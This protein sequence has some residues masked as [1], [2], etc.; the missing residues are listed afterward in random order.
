[1]GWRSKRRRAAEVPPARGARW[2]QRGRAGHAPLSSAR[3]INGAN[4]L[5]AGGR[6]RAA[7][8][9]A[10]VAAACDVPDPESE[11]D[12][13]SSPE[14]VPSDCPPPPPAMNP[15]AVEA[16]EEVNRIRKSVG[17][18]C[19]ELVP[20][21]A[22][23]AERHCQYFVS[24]AGACISRPHRESSDCRSFFG[25]TF[26]DRLRAAGY[27]RPSALRSDGLR[28]RRSNL[29]PDVARLCLAPVADPEPRRRA[30]RIR[31]RRPL[32][33]RRLRRRPRPVPCVARRRL[34]PRRPAQRPARLRRPRS[35][36]APT[37]P[38]RGWPS[39]YPITLY[40]A[41]LRVHDHRITV[42]GTDTPLDHEFLS[43]EDPRSEGLLVDEFMLYTWH[44]LTA[45][46]R[47]RVSIAGTREGAPA[48]FEWT[49]TTR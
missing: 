14:T 9:V 17:L 38:G 21:I 44:P 40:A 2:Q 20:E 5:T 36:R 27:T 10:L 39:G 43:P 15:E 22:H 37:P 3:P 1:M 11:L 13:F 26:G 8:G 23:A 42:E 35:P 18:G 4:R 6:I 19:I 12:F 31:R 46:T 34:P 49:F 47:Y 25:E 29:R 48:Q 33:H 45:Q 16:I 24:N 32:R 7:L 41:G 28:R 30:G